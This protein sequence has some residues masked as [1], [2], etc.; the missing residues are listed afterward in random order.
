MKSQTPYIFHP[1]DGQRPRLLPT[2][3]TD[4]KTSITIVTTIPPNR[5]VNEERT[6]EFE[7]EPGMVDGQEHRFVG[8]GEPHIDGDP[9]DLIIRIKTQP[10]PRLVLRPLCSVCRVW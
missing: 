9:G 5:L 6:L 2:F 7:I 4:N 3:A 1:L 8:E 10:H